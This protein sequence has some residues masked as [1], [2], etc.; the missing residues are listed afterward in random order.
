MLLHHWL[1]MH[2]SGIS[3]WA[4]LEKWISALDFSAGRMYASQYDRLL[5]SRMRRYPGSDCTVSRT[6]SALRFLSSD[7]RLY[8][9]IRRMVYALP[10]HRKSIPR[11]T[12]HRDALS[13]SLS[14]DCTCHYSFQLPDQKCDSCSIRHCTSRIIFISDFLIPAQVRADANPRLWR[15]LLPDRFRKNNHFPA[16]LH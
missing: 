3:P 10:D 7:R 12:C 2:S 15:H 9:R 1:G 8:R 6:Y 14:L 5:L 13:G 4:F 11:Q 16:E